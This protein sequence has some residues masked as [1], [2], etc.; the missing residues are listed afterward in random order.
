MFPTVIMSVSGNDFCHRIYVQPIF[1]DI[2]TN[3]Q[4]VHFTVQLQ[5]TIYT[6]EYKQRGALVGGRDTAQ[7]AKNVNSSN[8]HPER[9][10]KLRTRSRSSGF[11]KS[12]GKT[13]FFVGVPVPIFLVNK[14]HKRN[15]QQTRHIQTLT[16]FVAIH[17]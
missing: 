7:T 3:T 1:V 6:A 4:D 11:E 14:R 5:N 2:S 10:F 17:N 16:P 13:H 15:W 12:S 9:N 8:I